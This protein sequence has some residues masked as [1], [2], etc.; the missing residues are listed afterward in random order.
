MDIS[1]PRGPLRR[2]LD[3]PS[4]ATLDAVDVLDAVWTASQSVAISG[5]E[6]MQDGHELDEMDPQWT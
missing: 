4:S 6:W 3:A 2:Y 1:G 5:L